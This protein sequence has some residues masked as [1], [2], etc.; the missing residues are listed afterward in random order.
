MTYTSRCVFP[1]SVSS[2]DV[3]FK[4]SFNP[5]PAIVITKVEPVQVSMVQVLLYWAKQPRF[6]LQFMSIRRRRRSRIR[7]PCRFGQRGGGDAGR[8]ARPL[9]LL[10]SDAEGVGPRL[11]RRAPHPRPKAA[12]ERAVSLDEN[13][14][15]A[16]DAL[17]QVQF[18]Y[19][20]DFESAERA[21]RQALKLNPSDA[22]ARLHLANCLAARGRTEEA[23][24]E[25]KRA[26][27]HDPLSFLINREVGRMLYYARRY[28]EALAELKQAADMQPDSS[29]VGWWVVRCLLRKGMI[30]RAVN[31]DIT[32]RRNRDKLDERTMAELRVAAAKKSTILLAQAQR[33]HSSNLLQWHQ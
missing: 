18:L 22:D 24:T 31:A 3:T 6:G 11:R 30:D 23:V 5:P 25:I 15:E 1:T 17:G 19:D 20:H 28:D 8:R 9:R 2:G 14:P 7:R 29:A 26:R 21:H 27:Q 32:M 12:A 10:G 13:L 4:V 33:C 16:Y